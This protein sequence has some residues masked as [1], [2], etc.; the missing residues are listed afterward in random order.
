MATSTIDDARIYFVDKWPG[1]AQ[2]GS[3][4][5]EDAD[6]LI[7]TNPS[8]FNVTTASYEAGTKY[9]LYDATALGFVTFIYLQL[10]TQEGTLAAKDICSLQIATSEFDLKVTN[11]SD[12]DSVIGPMAI[13]LGAMTNDRYGWFQCGG[14][15]A[16]SNVSALG[17]NYRTET[18]VAAGPVGILDEANTFAF[19]AS[20]D[21]IVAF[22]SNADA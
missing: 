1:T 18:N 13:A 15:P 22:A 3:I 10:G 19:G 11:K 4:P 17:G 7:W 20:A 12:A 5:T 6:G 14:R 2:L 16:V 21:N 8:H 9:T